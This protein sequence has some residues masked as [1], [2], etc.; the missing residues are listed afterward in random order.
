MSG[1][2]KIKMV[3]IPF[4]ALLF[5]QL[6]RQTHNGQENIL[7]WQYYFHK[8]CHG[9]KEYHKKSYGHL[10]MVFKSAIIWEFKRNVRKYYDPTIAIL[11][12]SCDQ[13]WCLII[14]KAYSYHYNFKVY[15]TP[16]CEVSRCLALYSKEG[17]NKQEIPVEV[18]ISMRLLSSFL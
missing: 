6:G 16:V 7:N 17:A 9:V 10:T 4:V 5:Q 8:I 11:G 12:P 1:V 13:I 3:L 18:G 2:A 15:F 14:F